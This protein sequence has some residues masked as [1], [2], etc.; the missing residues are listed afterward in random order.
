MR[1]VVIFGVDNESLHPPDIAIGGMYMFA[2]ANLHLARWNTVLNL[3][4]LD[5][6]PR[7]DARTV[8]VGTPQP[9][10]VIARRRIP[11]W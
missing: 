2:A 1:Y 4:H 10:Y 11:V 9:V 8:I 3:G 6:Q 7:A 5:E